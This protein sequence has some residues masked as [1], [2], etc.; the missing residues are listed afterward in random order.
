MKFRIVS[1]ALALTTAVLFAFTGCSGSGALYSDP[2][3]FLS[4]DDSEMNHIEKET[5]PTT[6]E[7]TDELITTT[8]AAT[9]ET[10]AVDT[11][12]TVESPDTIT[13]DEIPEE[14]D[15]TEEATT[16]LDEIDITEEAAVSTDDDDMK[17]EPPSY[18][19]EISNETF[20]KYTDICDK[21]KPTEESPS[22]YIYLYNFNSSM[23]TGF[24]TDGTVVHTESDYGI[25]G[26]IDDRM[27][28]ITVYDHTGMK[29]LTAVYLQGLDASNAYDNSIIQIATVREFI[30]DSSSLKNGLHRIIA[31]FTDNS[32]VSLYFYINGNETLFCE[33]KSLTES[34]EKNYEKRRADFM[35][36]LADGDVTPE[37]SLSLEN[38]F[39]P[40]PEFDESHRC[41]T[42]RWIDLSNTI[43]NDNWSDE[44]KLY[45]L[46]AWIRENIAYDEF[47]RDQQK[48]RAQ[49]HG[50][51]SGKYSVYDLRAGIC[52]DYA[53][54]ITIMCRAHGIPAVTISSDEAHHEWNAVYVNNRWM[55]LD[56]CMSEQYCVGEDTSVR[57]KTTNGIYDGTFSIMVWGDT[58]AIPSDAAANQDIQ[59]DGNYIY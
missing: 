28:H 47:S 39:Y 30:F 1:S 9:V 38:I 44:Y 48:S 13:T 57:T 56:A 31:I 6:T 24:G 25:K 22:E 8:T 12:T 54:I 36:I 3:S 20:L 58:Y 49:Y 11:T 52:F 41:D 51:F 50:D 43:I 37:N 4:N 46:Q 5:D 42:Q 59:Q 26:T 10:T 15:L 16:S 35:R 55:E 2:E 17:P 29:S 18:I 27:M 14:A 21:Y 19:E 45:I 53:N 34:V 23:S 32:T 33:E 7:K 40:F